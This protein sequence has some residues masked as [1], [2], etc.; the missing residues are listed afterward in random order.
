M[1]KPLYLWLVR[2][3][4]DMHADITTLT[5]LT[6]LAAGHPSRDDEAFLFTG[7]KTHPQEAPDVGPQ[8]YLAQPLPYQPGDLPFAP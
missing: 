2:E 3:P 8:R 5:R 6:T 4:T 7:E 1:L